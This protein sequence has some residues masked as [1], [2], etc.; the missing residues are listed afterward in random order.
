[1]IATYAN[2]P[3]RCIS[4]QAPTLH[5]MEQ[6]YGHETANAWL[7]L[8]LEYINKAVG[9]QSKMSSEQIEI[10]AQSL[11]N[12]EDFQALKVTDVMLFVNQFVS[13][14]YGHFYG[15]VDAQVIGESLYKY[16]AWRRQRLAQILKQE[17]QAMQ[18]MQ[19]EQWLND[20]HN[21]S[22]EEYLKQKAEQEKKVDT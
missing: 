16:I 5:V 8:S 7:M 2:Y 21:I 11:L 3:D 22:R 20:P 12:N 19:R 4:G 9:V 14:K 1:M 10:V 13:G 15:A 18:R 6:A 17:Q